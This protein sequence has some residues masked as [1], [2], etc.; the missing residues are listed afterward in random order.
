MPF[1]RADRVY[2]RA[3]ERFFTF[4]GVQ[5]A[6]SACAALAPVIE[7]GDGMIRFGSSDVGALNANEYNGRVNVNRNHVAN[8][9]HPYSDGVGRLAER[10]EA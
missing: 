8:L 1:L 5:E 2:T 4:R 9:A 3:A 7:D 10:L 6:G